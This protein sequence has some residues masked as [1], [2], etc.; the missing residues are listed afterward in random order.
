MSKLDEKITSL[1]PES[2]RVGEEE[3]LAAAQAAGLYVS[4]TS[5]SWKEVREAKG[6]RDALG[7][8]ATW[9]WRK[10]V[11]G[12]KVIFLPH[13]EFHGTWTSDKEVHER[14]EAR[15]RAQ[16]KAPE[17]KVFD[18]GEPT[19]MVLVP[20]EVFIRE[21]EDRASVQWGEELLFLSEA[22]E[23]L[24]KEQVLVERVIAQL[25]LGLHKTN[26]AVV[27]AAW[28][29]EEGFRG[30]GWLLNAEA[31]EGDDPSSLPILKREEEDSGDA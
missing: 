23:L 9:Q 21:D 2:F 12:R 25:C 4:E 26:A 11:H 16:L 6:D 18:L 24:K 28:L 8:T 19:V 3:F 17:A 29:M 10:H 31:L 27:E 1:W 15:L 13:L 22:Q 30:F 20:R 5:G 7:S 14:L